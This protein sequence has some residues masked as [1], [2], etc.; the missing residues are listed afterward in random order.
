MEDNPNNYW[1]ETEES[2][3]TREYFL[4]GS[5]TDSAQSNNSTIQGYFTAYQ[6]NL[7]TGYPNIS[8]PQS[9]AMGTRSTF[10]RIPQ[11]EEQSGSGEEAIFNDDYTFTDDNNNDQE[12]EQNQEQEDTTTTGNVQQDM[13]R[14]L[15]A[16]NQNIQAFN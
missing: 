5:P 11:R 12:Q 9:A 6:T 2:L 3:T 15:E 4:P 16:L 10:S 13:V 8:T 1:D 7:I 14:I